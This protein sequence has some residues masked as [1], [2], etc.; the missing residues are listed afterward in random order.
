MFGRYMLVAAFGLLFTTAVVKAQTVDMSL[1]LYYSDPADTNSAGTWQLVALASDRG[2]AGLNVGFIGLN[3]NPVF[4]AP[5]GSGTGVPV[6]GFYE[7]YNNGLS[8]WDLDQDGNSATLDMLF[9]QVPLFSP[10]PQGLFYDVGVPGGATQ[11]GENGTPPI[12]GFVAG[13]NVPWNFTDTLGDLFDD[14]ILNGSGAFEGGVLLASGTFNANS[15]PAFLGEV[16]N[17]FIAMGTSA[18]PPAP[19]S[20][21]AATLSTQIRDNTFMVIPEP[22]TLMLAGFA[23]TLLGSGRRRRT[24]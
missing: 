14:G 21:V 18:D 10:G 1:D 6:A 24:N 12:A 9:G 23:M 13:N 4:E 19:G 7:F 20:I 11:P 17:A 22:S 3:Q 5:W 15:S 2:L 16:A 8:P